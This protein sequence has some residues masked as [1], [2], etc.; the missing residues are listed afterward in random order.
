MLTATLPVLTL[1]LG[2]VLTQWND[3]KR[4]IAQLR[5]EQR[6]HELN[7]EQA[8]QD[9]RET[10][11]LKHLSEVHAVLHEL[12]MRGVECQ[13]ARVSDVPA[14]EALDRLYETNRK[15]IGM[16]GFILVEDVRRLADDASEYI[17]SLASI[18]MLVEGERPSIPR[19]AQL[20]MEA[21]EAIANRVREIYRDA[22]SQ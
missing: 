15:Y 22:E 16:R 14:N 2:S 13:Q 17:N 20:L 19:A 12:Y 11:E 1:I 18:V 21:Q 9:R 8:R 3:T 6:L 5:R 4:E 7:R 10:F